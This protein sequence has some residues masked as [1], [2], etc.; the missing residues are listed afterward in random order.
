MKPYNYD[1]F[2]TTDY[3]FDSVDGPDIGQKAPDL[4]LATAE[5]ETRNLLDFSGDFLVLEMGSITCP[6]FQSRRTIMERLER[7][8]NNVSTVG[9]PLGHR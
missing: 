3:D 7:D 8:C 2:S 6:L 1:E 9:S 4:L 5:G